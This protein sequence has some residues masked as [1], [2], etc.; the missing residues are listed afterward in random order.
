[1]ISKLEKANTQESA[2]RK[3][4]LGAIVL[5]VSCLLAGIL[6]AADVKT[7]IKVRFEDVDNIFKKCESRYNFWAGSKQKDKATGWLELEGLRGE[8]RAARDYFEVCFRAERALLNTASEKREKL[9]DGQVSAE[10]KEKIRTWLKD[11]ATRIQKAEEVCK[12][13][14]PYEAKAAKMEQ[15]VEKWTISLRP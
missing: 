10:D 14:S 13:S 7:E 15:S 4:V 2:K 3:R 12:V 6:Q 1:M 11:N 8:W 9:K 5:A